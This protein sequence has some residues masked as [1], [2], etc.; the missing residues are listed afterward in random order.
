MIEVL[1]TELDL[2]RQILDNKNDEAQAT[3]KK[4]RDLEKKGHQ[5]YRPPEKD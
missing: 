3:V 1:K 5:D 4:L 2:E